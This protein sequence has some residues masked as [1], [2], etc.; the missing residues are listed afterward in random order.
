MQ[1]RISV[2]EKAPPSDAGRKA[3]HPDTCPYTDP[4]KCSISYGSTV[5]VVQ[6]KLA[7]GIK[8]KCYKRGRKSISQKEHLIQVKWMNKSL[9]DSCEQTSKPSSPIVSGGRSHIQCTVHVEVQNT[10]R[11]LRCAYFSGCMCTGLTSNTFEGE[12]VRGAG[13][14]R[15]TPEF[16][17]YSSGLRKVEKNSIIAK[18]HGRPYF[19]FLSYVF[20]S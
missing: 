2:R 16:W 3:R 20:E 13:L 14:R 8:S 19:L 11:G 1:P 5:C 10:V 15:A 17:M 12:V 4:S 18:L 6:K 7:K 9:L